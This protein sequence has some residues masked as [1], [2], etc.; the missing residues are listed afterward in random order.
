MAEVL[1]AVASG[2]TVVAL[3]IQVGHSIKKLKNL[4]DGIK[5]APAD[6]RQLIDDITCLDQLICTF[7]TDQ[8]AQHQNHGP[9]PPLRPSL[10]MTLMSLRETKNRLQEL[11]DDLSRDINSQGKIRR[12]KGVARFLLGKDKLEKHYA[13]LERAKSTFTLA[14]SV[15][16]TPLLQ[17]HGVLLRE[18][19]ELLQNQAQMMQRPTS[20]STACVQKHAPYVPYGSQSTWLEGT[21]LQYCFGSFYYEQISDLRPNIDKDAHNKLKR[22]SRQ[23]RIKVEYISPSWLGSRLFQVV[24]RHSHN[25]WD[26]KLRVWNVV[27]YDSPAFECV[28]AG[29]LEGLKRLL[30]DKQ[31]S[32]NDK[33]DFNGDTLLHAALAKGHFEI[34]QFLIEQGIDVNAPNDRRETALTSYVW[35]VQNETDGSTLFQIYRTIISQLDEPFQEDR[36]GWNAM[37][38]IRGKSDW[39]DGIFELMLQEFWQSTSQMTPYT[40]AQTVLGIASHGYVDVQIWE[41]ILPQGL[42]D[43]YTVQVRNG[44]GATLLTDLAWYYGQCHGFMT[45]SSLTTGWFYNLL[46]EGISAGADL[47]CLDVNSQTPFLR[48]FEYSV[49]N[50]NPPFGMPEG[51]K[52]WLDALKCAGVDLLKYGETEKLLCIQGLV[53]TS[54]CREF[55]YTRSLTGS[56]TPTLSACL[57]DPYLKIGSYATLWTTMKRSMQENSGSRLIR[58]KL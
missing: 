56:P 55:T 27:P 14:E 18:I 58:S 23:K 32:L 42:L 30:V 16:H 43:D 48:C 38:W 7:E 3:P 24:G 39:C 36:L 57:L 6:V 51:V 52:T 47:H 4:W 22:G 46:N 29:D 37:C 26:T 9:P 53:D 17:G 1:G 19:H 21:W 5:E 11:A 44:Y 31:T 41:K 8:I 33:L 15:Y 13:A 54:V 25:G 28:E 40:R 20:T 10:S 34:G 35:G 45:A 2:L 49:H 50:S 12:G